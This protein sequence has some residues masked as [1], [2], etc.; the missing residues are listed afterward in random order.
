MLDALIKYREKNNVLPDRI[1][2][3]RDGVSD[4]QFSGV[5]EYEVPQMKAAFT[6]ISENYAYKNILKIFLFCVKI[7]FFIFLKYSPKL[8]VLVVK[9]RGNSRFFWKG[10]RN[11]FQNAPMGTVIDNT[12]VKNPGYISF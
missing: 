10:G 7:K 2:V 6:D 12:I 8:T 5:A 3:Y 1:F 4:G 9:K 11:E